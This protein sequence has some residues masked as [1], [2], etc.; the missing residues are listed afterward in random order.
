[1]RGEECQR[2][3]EEERYEGDDICEREERN[4]GHF[5]QWMKMNDLRHTVFCFQGNFR[6]TKELGRKFCVKISYK[7]VGGGRG[8]EHPFSCLGERKRELGGQL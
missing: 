7:R 6:G 5:I 1:M 2:S 4:D 8:G 3:Q